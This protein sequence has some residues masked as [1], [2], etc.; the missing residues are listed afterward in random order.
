[1]NAKDRR[2]LA[3]QKKSGPLKPEVPANQTGLMW[4]LAGFFAVHKIL[5]GG[6]KK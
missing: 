5:K 1:M 4:R 2:L 3:A 6:D